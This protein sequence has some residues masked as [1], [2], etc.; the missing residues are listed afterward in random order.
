MGVGVGVGVGVPLPPPDPDPDPPLAP[1]PSPA[2]PPAPVLPEIAGLAG[3]SS[4]VPQP[5]SATI[6]DTHN[7][8]A[9]SLNV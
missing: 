5:V 7:A 8:I 1:P 6:D 3:V 4:V 9:V 2:P